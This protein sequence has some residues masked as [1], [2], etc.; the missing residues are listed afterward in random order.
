MGSQNK[1]DGKHWFVLHFIR[2]TITARPQTYI[3]TFNRDIARVEL[4]APTIKPAQIVDGQVVFKE[5]LL[6][7]HY[8][9]VKGT[10]KDV[11]ELCA[12]QGNGLSLLVDRGSEKRYGIVS[13]SAMHSFRQIARLYDNTLPFYNIA[14]I[15]LEE[16]DLV[17]IVDGPYA[18]LSGTFMPKSRSSKG[19]LVIAATAAIGTVLWD[20]EARYIRILRFAR[21]TRRQYDQLEAFIQKLLPVMR[22]FHAGEA[23]AE[24][25]KSQLRVFCTRM[26]V[27]APDNHKLEAKLLGTLMCAQHILGDIRAAQHSASRFQRRRKAVTNQWTQALISLFAAIMQGNTDS[28]TETYRK[29]SGT[30]G[31]L[32]ASKTQLLD[33]YRYYLRQ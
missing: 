6:T 2:P 18:G 3:D 33:E 17:E 23:L 19:N 30:E 9:F 4:F 31:K 20:I 12:T 22:K 29:I 5:R 28:L 8:V 32:T 25:D 15:A 24:K 11:K 16:G 13:D 10:L 7:Y 26:E 14:D 27:V 21:D 1:H